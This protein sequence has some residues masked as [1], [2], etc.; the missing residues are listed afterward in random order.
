[1][2]FK[3]TR[4]Q[5][6]IQKAAWEF[7]KGEF[8]PQAA[9]DMDRQE[10][11]PREAWEKAGELGFIGLNVPDACGGGELG[12]VEAVL[13]AETLCRRD[14]TMG[15]AIGM[16]DIAVEYLRRFGSEAQMHRYLPLMCQGRML[17]GFSFED[18]YPD[19]AGDPSGCHLA[20]AGDLLEIS[21]SK[22]MV[23]NAPMADLYLLA[24]RE[25]QASS[26]DGAASL[27]LVE[28]EADNI[29]I[30]ATH[31]RLGMRLTGMG[32]CGF[33][34]T[35]V[36]NSQRLGQKGRANLHVRKVLPLFQV[37]M[38]AM[39]VGIAQ[40]AL[41][42]A[43]D[44]VRQRI[45]FGKKIGQF[46]VV[47]H[48]LAQMALT[49][50]QARS[51]TYRAAGLMDAGKADMVLTAAAKLCACDAAVHVTYEAIQLHGGYG[52]MTE[53]AIERFYRDAKT[54]QIAGGNTDRLKDSIADQII[55]KIR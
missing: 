6:E 39:A 44:H 46:Q 14:A 4:T 53:Y 26:P 17:C 19:S 22:T 31:D 34:R 29:S 45:Q 36:P 48:K 20:I 21:G 33:D 23:V 27:V 3:L 35:R 49:V 24:C 12:H 32:V 2:D 52:Y 42:R 25:T 28:K 16:A 9:I 51:L 15:I 13:V 54:L 41:E 18:L 37:K 40:G 7:A 43:L 11:F 8:D 10:A 30:R 50:E 38:A 47:R 1:M 5:K 55:G